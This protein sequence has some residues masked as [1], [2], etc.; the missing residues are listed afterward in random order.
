MDLNA[1]FQ[2]LNEQ[3]KKLRAEIDRLQKELE[4][5]KQAN[6]TGS[7]EVLDVTLF[8]KYTDMLPEMIYEVDLRGRIIFANQ[9][10]L[11]FFGYTREDLQRGVNISEIFPEDYKKMIAN[12]S[13]LKSPEQ[14]SSNEYIGRKKDGTPVPIVTHS[15]AV[16]QDNKIEK[17]RGV[18]TDISRQK[19]YEDQI[20]REKAFLE[21]LVDSTPLAITITDING[22]IIRINNEFTNLFG[23]THEEA[24][25]HN[26]YEL[27]VPPELRENSTIPQYEPSQTRKEIL[28]TIRK[29]KNGRRLNVL[30]VRTTIV[31]NNEVTAMLAIYQDITSEKKNKL[32]Q[33]VVFN[34]SD[35]ALKQ[36]EIKDLYPSI[37]HEINKIWETNNLFIALYNKRT[38][39]LSLP[40]FADE[41]DDFIELP[42][43]NTLTGW[44]INHNRAILLKEKDIVELEKAGE[45]GVIG[46]PCK[47]WM[48]V[49][50]KVDKEIIGAICMQ[51]Y[52]DENKFSPEDLNVLEFIA[53][54]IAIAI[55]RM[56][57]LDNLVIARQK[58]EE[59]ALSKQQFMSTMSHEIRTPM[60][61]VI[62]ITNLLLQGNPREDQR[63]FLKTLKFSGNHLLTLVND[64]LDYNKIELGKVIFEHSQFNLTS[65]LNDI[66][67]SYS[68]R[69]REKNL[70]FDLIK[71]SDLPEEVLGDSVRLNQI[72]SNLLSNALKFTQRGS[73]TINIKELKR[74]GKLSTI[75]FSVKDTGIGIPK[76]KLAVIFESFS[77]GGSD[78][79]RNFGGTGLGLTICKKLVELQGGSISV[80]SEQGYGSTFKFD[81]TFGVAETDFQSA[82]GAPAETFEKLKG[83]KILVA[84]DNKINYFVV[85]KFLTGWGVT[86]THAENGQ[87]VLD[88]I[89]KSDF[90]LLLLDLQMPVL[91][92]IETTRIIRNSENIKVK[93]IPVVALTAA[94]ISESQVNIEDLKINDYILKPFKPKD[95][96]DRIAKH[97]R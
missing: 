63:D 80:E 39:S 86:V 47:I 29:D 65:F 90:D 91:D 92:G 74:A 25:N 19:E 89:E 16:F 56:T 42:A 87:V 93:N 66:V 84:E 44:V 94:M 2:D 54:Q 79:T 3:N 9:R 51:D 10:G 53:N 60:N 46:T 95:L 40:F 21:H 36:L 70:E 31:L 37:V 30:L 15:F 18:V 12:L 52:H 26:I 20:K 6:S 83:K 5:L 85:N 75:E 41:K 11:S 96:Y 38:E 50:L 78:I 24:I 81:L 34:I 72:L 1:E 88:I 22:K 32:L 43:K 7:E 49:P 64:V 82:S 62:G 68:I 57:L 58:A 17:Y 45:I 69:A 67:R 59:A 76:D 77:Q 33:E 14:T 4:R 35:T 13:G 28:E 71:S 61:E 48:G 73:I 27:V 23:Y 55:Q 97:V 8:E